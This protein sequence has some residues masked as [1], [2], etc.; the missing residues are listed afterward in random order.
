MKRIQSNPLHRMALFCNSQNENFCLL[1]FV[2]VAFNIH[3]HHPEKWATEEVHN[4][5]CSNCKT[6]L[7]R[8]KMVLIFFSKHQHHASE[9]AQRKLLHHTIVKRVSISISQ[10]ATAGLACNTRFSKCL[11]L[12]FVLLRDMISPAELNNCNFSLAVLSEI[13]IQISYFF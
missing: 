13:F 9:T 6:V 4:T 3:V 5:E 8:L 1:E 12:S 10:L 11:S 2:Q 7:Y